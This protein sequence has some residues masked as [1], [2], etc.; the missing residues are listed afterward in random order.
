MRKT[1]ILPAVPLMLVLMQS[2]IA[3]LMTE[4][5]IPIGYSPGISGKYSYIGELVA[6]DETA[7]TLTIR[8]PRGEERFRV[9]EHTFIW[10]DR[11]KIERTNLDGDF[12]DCRVGRRAEIM[13]THDD[14][15]VAQWVKIEITEESG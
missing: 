7:H 3:Q 1:A 6:V 15:S 12:D 10:L 9:T 13:Y 14:K 11:T 8:S 5:Y 4:R 2:A